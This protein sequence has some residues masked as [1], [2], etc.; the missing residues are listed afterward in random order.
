MFLC[1]NL[2]GSNSVCYRPRCLVPRP[3]YCPC[4]LWEEFE[5]KKGVVNTQEVDNL[6]LYLK[7]H[8]FLHLP[9]LP[10]DRLLNTF[11]TLG[12][13]LTKEAF[14]TKCHLPLLSLGVFRPHEQTFSWLDTFLNEFV[15]QFFR[16]IN[17]SGLNK[18]D[19][20]RKIATNRRHRGMPEGWSCNWAF[21]MPLSCKTYV[22]HG[23]APSHWCTKRQLPAVSRMQVLIPVLSPSHEVVIGRQEALLPVYADFSSHI[24]VLAPSFQCRAVLTYHA[25]MRGYSIYECGIL[26]RHQQFLGGRE[27]RGGGC[28]KKPA[29]EN[30]RL[31]HLGHFISRPGALRRE[32]CVLKYLY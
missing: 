6:P 29:H 26:R 30:L 31:I 11:H 9:C 17:T 23:L 19:G 27:G 14:S 3:I 13:S 25:V 21:W 2:A 5:P 12:S 4:R 32:Q 7:R 18:S 20:H 22:R 28:S 24:Y 1:T 8:F 15:K 16:S 10:V